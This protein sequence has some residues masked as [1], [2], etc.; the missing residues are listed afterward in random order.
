MKTLD[1]DAL[2][3]RWND[4]QQQIDAQLHLDAERLRATLARRTQTAFRRHSRWLL[5]GTLG[6]M[7]ALLALM[8]FLWVHRTDSVYQ[9]LS[10]PLTLLALG[11][12][13]VNVRQWLTLSRL[14]IS[15]PVS[16]V[17]STL[18]TLR[19]RRLRMTRWILLSSVLLWMPLILV[20]FKG[21]TGFDLLDVLHPSVLYVNLLVGVLFIPLA[22][23]IGQLIA[24]RYAGTPAYQRFLDDSAGY[25]WRRARSELDAQ[26]RFDD[27]LADDGATSVL[28]RRASHADSL[29]RIAQPLAALKRRLN[30]AI[31]IYAALMLGTGTFNALNGGHPQFLIPALMLHFVWLAHLVM[32]ISQR[33]HLARWQAASET[34]DALAD[35]VQGIA[36]WRAR[37]ARWTL[38]AVP[39]LLLA[40]AQVLARATAGIDLWAVLHPLTWVTWLAIAV[41]ASAWLRRRLNQLEASSTP[42]AIDWIS[43]GTRSRCQRLIDQLHPLTHP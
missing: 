17:Q 6:S 8:L 13:V 29:L 33:H 34:V 22:L 23:A 11:E 3:G 14:D 2:R 31:A 7:V 5:L 35:L 21:L 26:Q 15:A 30:A 1:L 37:L 32:A 27:Q 16:T 28:A 19:S 40:V 25:S 41:A 4:S 10:L 39:I 43:I 20:L 12:V 24:R 42:A 38:I 9:F 36:C 18:E